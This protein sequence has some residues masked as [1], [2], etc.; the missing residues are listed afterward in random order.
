MQIEKY[1]IP[2]SG[3]T[4]GTDG[5]LAVSQGGFVTDIAEQFLQVA[6][7]LDPE[8]AQKPDDTD[9]ND[10]ETINVYTVGVLR[11]TLELD[12]RLSSVLT[13][14]VAQVRAYLPA[15]ACA[16]SAW[17]QLMIVFLGGRW[18]NSETGTRSDVPHN[19]IY[20]LKDTRPNLHFLTGVHV[21]HVT[22]DEWV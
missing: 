2:G 10:L 15:R 3:P 7:T 8:R 16:V 5:P 6:R 11:L 1:E 17:R 20:P 14:E 22:F 4:H 21:K 13:A 18:I 12:R 19:M 9:S